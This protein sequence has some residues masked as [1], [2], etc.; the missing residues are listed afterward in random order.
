MS[1][2]SFGA[3]KLRNKKLVDKALDMGMN[4]FDTAPDYIY[5]ESEITLGKVIKEAKH[6]RDKMIITSKLCLQGTGQMHQLP[7]TSVTK[8]IKGVEDSLKR[9]HTDYIDFMCLH[10]LGEYG[11]TYSNGKDLYSKRLYDGNML[12]A[13]SRLKK[14]W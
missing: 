14:R 1:D 13:I 2:I 11:P 12:E 3:I 5:G 6:K 9:L 7:G 4:Y 8:L 10:A